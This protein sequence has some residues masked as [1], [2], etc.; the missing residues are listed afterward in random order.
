MENMIFARIVGCRDV[1]IR[2]GMEECFD[3][4]EVKV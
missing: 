3:V 4:E 2:G 1:E